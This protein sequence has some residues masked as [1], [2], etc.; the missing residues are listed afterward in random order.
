MKRMKNH[1]GYHD[2]TA[3]LAVSRCGRRGRRDKRGRKVPRLTYELG[4]LPGFAHVPGS[5]TGQISGKK[6]RKNV[7]KTDE[8]T[9]FK[10]VV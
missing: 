7:E 10:V 6:T 1:E 4:E 5:Q 9:L 2:P 8:I 3:C